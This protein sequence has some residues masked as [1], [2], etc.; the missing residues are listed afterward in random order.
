[1][2]LVVGGGGWVGVGLDWI[3]LNRVNLPA[4]MVIAAGISLGDFTAA[5]LF[6]CDGLVRA[7]AILGVEATMLIDLVWFGVIGWLINMFCRL[8][9]GRMQQ[10]S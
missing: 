7:A 9:D 5:T 2:G 8:T 1:M 4:R 6:S 10:I 3:E